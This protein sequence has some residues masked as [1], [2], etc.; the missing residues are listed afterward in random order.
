MNQVIRGDT[1]NELT[2]SIMESV[3]DGDV[4]TSRNG[5][6]HYLNN[7]LTE[8]TNP[9]ARHVHLHGRKN[10]IFATIA[11]TFWV[12]AGMDVLDPYMSMYLPRAKDYSD[13][14]GVTWYGAYGVRMHDHDQVNS[15]VK[16]F[17]DEGL[18]T[19][20][21]VMSI[22]HAEKDS[23]ANRPEGAKDIPCNNLLHFYVR[24]GKLNCNAFSRSGDVVWGLTNINIF[25]WTVLMEHIAQEIGVDVGTYSHFV[26]NL[27]IYDFT[28]S[29]CENVVSTEMQPT[30]HNNV[31][32]VFP[33][34][35]E[36]TR[37][38]F[39]DLVSELTQLIEQGNDYPI[40]NNILNL[41]S[42]YGVP[43]EGN[44]LWEYAR[45]VTAYTQAKLGA[46]LRLELPV[47]D[48]YEAVIHS[49]FRKFG[50]YSEFRKV[51]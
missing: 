34:G 40:N 36:N 51:G 16:T 2:V 45:A 49:P 35:V 25:E 22:Y 46:N 47:G 20:R 14:G 4:S 5:Q 9:R 21:A 32:M 37:K 12:M 26:T 33:E 23:V 19:R 27:H 30:G 3:L 50:V 39:E 17:K 38:F 31:P 1:L 6:V 43:R 10:N 44:L 42:G 7:A 29:Q 13:D 18:D 15:V 41:F 48:F 28:K 11:E 8:L 24:D